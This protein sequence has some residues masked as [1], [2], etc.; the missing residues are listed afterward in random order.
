MENRS[1]SGDF[2]SKDS[3]IST[4][5][6]TITALN[7]S[8]YNV[9]SHCE[10]IVQS[11]FYLFIIFA[12]V[13]IAGNAIVM[14]ILGF[15]LCRNAFSVYI[16]NLAMAD[17]LFLSFFFISTFPFISIYV[18]SFLFVVK[19]LAYVSGLSI[20][21][22]ISVERCLSVLWPI[23]YRCQRPR[24]TS[25]VTCALLWALSLLLSL[26]HG[27]A[28]GFLFNNLDSFQC[29]TLNYF[30]ASWLIVLFV[31]LCVSSLTLL[32]RIFCGSQRIPVTRLCV[33]IV[34]T[35]LFSLIFGFPLG[36]YYHLVKWFGDLDYAKIC[37][38]DNNIV[39][40]LSCVNSCAN[41]IIYFLIGS[42]RHRRFQ[43]KSLKLLLQRA[44][45]DTP[46]NEGGER[47]CPRKTEEREP[48]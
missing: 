37:N 35:V 15:Q 43:P 25:A 2:L 30:T 14:W 46:E 13:G 48:L 20:L 11:I 18:Y 29:Q 27:A 7:G 5:E 41:P 36:I 23:W 24:Y 8:T 21:S 22:A 26:L 17:F 42:I 34:L 3:N 9:S 28:C 33:I 44:L 1:I 10:I 16:L 19:K 32:V 38:L 39:S 31:V 12:L 40:L 4:W 6:T 45:Q 47:A